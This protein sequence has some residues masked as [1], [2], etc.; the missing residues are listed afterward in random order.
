M[1]AVPDPERMAALRSALHRAQLRLWCDQLRLELTEPVRL[2]RRADVGR[3]LARTMAAT[4]ILDAGGLCA[5]GAPRRRRVDR[6][7]RRDRLDGASVRPISGALPSRRWRARPTRPAPVFAATP[8]PSPPQP[9]FARDVGADDLERWVSW[10]RFV[11]G[12]QVVPETRGKDLDLAFSGSAHP[13]A[14]STRWFD[15]R[16]LLATERTRA[17]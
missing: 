9:L 5:R 1:E 13:R 6:R 7:S 15:G 12:V 4:G 3:W 16:A 8:P 17:T 11:R 14:R 10:T 2:P